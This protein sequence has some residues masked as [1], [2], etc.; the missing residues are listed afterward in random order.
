MGAE[1]Q[2]KTPTQG[3]VLLG[4][5]LVGNMASPAKEHPPFDLPRQEPKPATRSR[6]LSAQ[7]AEQEPCF[8]SFA[9]SLIE[10]APDR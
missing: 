10:E 2:Y 7:V 5:N 3:L 6:L 8:R 1:F 9:V 4:A